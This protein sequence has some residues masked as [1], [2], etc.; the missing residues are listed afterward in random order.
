MPN[1]PLEAQSSYEIEL[2]MD[3]P[4]GLSTSE[5][6]IPYPLIQIDVPKSAKLEGK[7]LKKHQE[8][9]RNEF[10]QAPYERIVEAWPARIR[11]Q[12][13]RAPKE[14][15]AFEINVVAYVTSADGKVSFVRERIRLPLASGATSEPADATTSQ[16]G[17]D[18]HLQ[19]GDK[20][21]DF[22][23]P[24]G[25]KEKVSL[26]SYRGSKNVIVTTYRAHW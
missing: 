17:E 16:W 22:T 7:V 12:L 9:A 5:A 26:K 1:E 8:L 25:E 24:T 3:V 21:K 13:I 19:I 23:L 11:F 4:E 2:N 15:E 18:R 14:D 20:A 10:L 6:G